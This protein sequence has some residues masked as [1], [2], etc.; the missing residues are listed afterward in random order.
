VRDLGRRV[1]LELGRDSTGEPILAVLN[2]LPD[3]MTQVHAFVDERAIGLPISDLPRQVNRAARVAF[4]SATI[5]ISGM[6]IA[7]YGLKPDPDA[8]RE[9]A[10]RLII[11]PDIADGIDQ[12]LAS[13][14]GTVVFAEQHF[15]AL[16]R[17]AVK[18]SDRWG[19]A[20]LRS[21][22]SHP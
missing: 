13:G 10:K 6:A 15:A 9:L 19:L 20:D 14:K 21:E 7:T 4:E 12:A 2:S 17:L 11:D 3:S 16:A 18:H 1:A 8:Q 5:Y 22:G